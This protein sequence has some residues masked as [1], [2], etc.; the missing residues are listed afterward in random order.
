MSSRFQKVGD[1][2]IQRSTHVWYSLPDG[3]NRWKCVLCGEI[4]IIPYT[5]LPDDGVV[6]KVIETLTPEERAM[7]PHENP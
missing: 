6:P 2:N 3:S 5:S 1:P 4:T 7:C